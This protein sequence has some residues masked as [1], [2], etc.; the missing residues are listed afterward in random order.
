MGLR[1]SEDHRK[2]NG[3]RR[4]DRARRWPI[5][6][7]PCGIQ[8]ASR[9]TGGLSLNMSKICWV[10]WKGRGGSARRWNRERGGRMSTRL[11]MMN[12]TNGSTVYVQGKAVF[13]RCLAEHRHRSIISG[14]MG[15]VGGGTTSSISANIKR[16]H[17]PCWTSSV[18]CGKLFGFSS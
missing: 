17:P 5:S 13:D 15:E 12:R 11:Q 6:C 4:P 9:A 7:S 8:L 1:P 16:P 18:S 14:A 2:L 10:G 3:S